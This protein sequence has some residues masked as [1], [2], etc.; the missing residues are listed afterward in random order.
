MLRLSSL[1]CPR[2]TS[3]LFVRAMP[4]VKCITDYFAIVRFALTPVM[5]LL[6]VRRDRRSK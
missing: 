6:Q 3:A 1:L 2:R 5:Y 4:T